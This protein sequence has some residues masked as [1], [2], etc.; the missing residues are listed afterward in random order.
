M[1]NLINIKK[2]NGF[3]G[4]LLDVMA[5]CLEK[6]AHKRITLEE[7]VRILGEIE[8]ET[9]LRDSTYT[10][11]YLSSDPLNLYSFSSNQIEQKL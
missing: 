1:A 11:I 4:K 7:V 6:D 10:H 3:N 9:Y 8:R 5:R 2:R